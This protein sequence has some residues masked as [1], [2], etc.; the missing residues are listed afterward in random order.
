MLVLKKTSSN[1][2]GFTLIE[3]LVVIAIIGIL[4]SILLP[5]T[6]K[7]REAAR[8]ISCANNARQ[9]A[10]ASL[11]FES[12][13][14]SFPRPA[15]NLGQSYQGRNLIVKG[16]FF[17]T[18]PFSESINLYEEMLERAR[19]TPS[20]VD[21][22]IATIDF[23]NPTEIG[24]F[25]L[26]KCPSMSDAE[27]IVRNNLR[28]GEVGPATLPRRTRCDYTYCRGVGSNAIGRGNPQF[29]PGVVSG[30]DKLDRLAEVTD[31][32][33]NTI[34]HGETQGIVIGNQRAQ[35]SSIVT[36]AALS[37]NAAFV[38]LP[39]GWNPNRVLSPEP[40]LLSPTTVEASFGMGEPLEMSV[41][42]S[43][44]FSS[45]HDGIV[46]FAFADGSTHLISTTTSP[47][48]LYNL[49]TRSGGEVN[50]KL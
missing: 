2:H 39:D 18:L 44:Q 31:G 45:P 6:Q 35:C 48:V 22:F 10:L 26:V 1:S 41:L 9:L 11:N 37:M 29:L 50:V 32:A 17:A 25:P 36:H 28:P 49:A 7:V 12:S 38:E 21:L 16:P 34:L 33:S 13:H 5:A 30:N 42:S 4:V 23:D 14:G 43:S 40:I 46:V 3:L 24:S 47:E 19:Q 8:R 20:S 27:V 15:E